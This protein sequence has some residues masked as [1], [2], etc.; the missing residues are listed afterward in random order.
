[1]EEREED[2][3]QIG[4]KVSKLAVDICYEENKRARGTG[5]ASMRDCHFTEGRKSEI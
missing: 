2:G 3:K 5:S 4:N 1:M